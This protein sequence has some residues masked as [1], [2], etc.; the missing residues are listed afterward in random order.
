M[1][2]GISTAS[3]FMRKQ[4]EEAIPLI[5]SLGVYNAEVFLATF[6]EYREAF[7]RQVEQVKGKVCV[8]SVHTLNTN[9][10][11]QLFHLSERVR[12]DAYYWL[13][14]VCKSAQILGAKYY[15][16][17]GTARFKRSAKSG[18][19]DNFANF[20]KGFTEICN[21]CQKYDVTLCLENVEWATYNRVGV[22][23]KIA[24]EVPA[25]RGVLDIKQ[26]RIS[27]TPYEQY[28]EEMGE[29]ITHVHLSDIDEQG[30][31][32]LPGRGTFDFDT[33]VKRLKDVGFTGKLF[34]EVYR[35]NFETVDELKTSCQ[36][37]DEILYKNNCYL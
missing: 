24:D 6:F 35:D 33:L 2:T 9:F 12:A 31:M 1:Q 5:E 37:I 32:C 17:H 13:E 21:R 4:T 27:E 34:L 11:P 30:K 16:F 26:A 8:N 22:F 7:A 15:T 28:L 19:N 23:S 25:L 10:E 36:F 18:N 29:K 3:L 14:E 20:I